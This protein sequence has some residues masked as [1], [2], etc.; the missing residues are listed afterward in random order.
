MEVSYSCESEKINVTPALEDI[1]TFGYV[2]GCGEVTE[3]TYCPE[4]VQVNIINL[5]ANATNINL[6]YDSGCPDPPGTGCNQCEIGVELDTVLTFDNSLI[7]SVSGTRTLTEDGVITNTT[8]ITS[9][10]QL[11]SYSVQTYD[12]F[13][14]DWTLTFVLTN[15]IVFYATA[16]VCSCGGQF[17]PFDDIRKTVDY[18]YE[19]QFTY[20]TEGNSSFQTIGLTDGFYTISIN[21]ETFCIIIECEETF[22][23]KI[24]GLDV[25]CDSCSDESFELFSLYKM[26]EF[27]D[28]CC[29]KNMLYRKLNTKLLECS[30]C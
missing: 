3:I 22:T 1:V 5:V 13:T 8:I 7:S 6:I 15:G 17:C 11:A 10:S 18:E 9:I 27:C 20:E 26:L 19:C 14:V 12:D 2:K 16:Q 30:S 25:G 24:F 23:C 21:G 29:T 28:D 4:G